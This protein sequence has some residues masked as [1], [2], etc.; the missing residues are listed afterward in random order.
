MFVRL[1]ERIR[2]KKKFNNGV[3]RPVLMVPKYTNRK[4]IPFSNSIP[5]LD[6]LRIFFYIDC[7]G[8][9]SN[10]VPPP[11]ESQLHH[12]ADIVAICST[13]PHQSDAHLLKCG[14]HQRRL[15]RLQLMAISFFCV[16]VRSLLTKRNFCLYEQHPWRL[17]ELELT[18]ELGR[19]KRSL[20]R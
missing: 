15:I 19:Q 9:I 20:R 14:V 10:S 4:S 1:S 3:V 16:R 13:I 7:Y 17:P 11:R 8:K 12:T 6:S 2:R 18:P 5:R